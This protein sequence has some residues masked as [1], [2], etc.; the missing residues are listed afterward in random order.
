MAESLTRSVGSD[1]P[2]RGQIPLDPRLRENGDA[3][4]PIVQAVPDSAAAQVLSEVAK[5]LSV[6][7]RGLAGRLLNVSPAG[8]Q[9]ATRRSRRGTRGPFVRSCSTRG[10]SVRSPRAPVA[11]ACN[12]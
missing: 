7:S 8:R 3:G 9:P 10:A 2:L 5:K 1:V 12:R 6:R 11:C 4:T